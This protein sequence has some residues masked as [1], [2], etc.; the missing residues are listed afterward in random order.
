VTRVIEIAELFHTNRATREQH[1]AQYCG[2]REAK[3]ER[4]KEEKKEIG[5][6]TSRL[7]TRSLHHFI[8]KRAENVLKTFPKDNNVL[9]AKKTFVF[10]DGLHIINSNVH[11]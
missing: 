6:H 8:S 2:E 5:K 7:C 10:F 1:L 9:R 11:K 4:Q 3:K